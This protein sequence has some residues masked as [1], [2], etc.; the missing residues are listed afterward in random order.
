VSVTGSGSAGD[1]RFLRAGAVV[2]V[3]GTVLATVTPMAA[4]ASAAFTGSI[5]TSGLLGLVFA[6]RNLQLFE[7]T[8]R[9]DAP[10]AVL[11]LVFGLWFM[12]APLLYD[13][14]FLA[15]AGTQLGGLLVSSFAA[16]MSLSGLVGPHG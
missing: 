9:V 16:H 13:V 8:G 5:V 10:A 15:T 7:R 12:L 1:R 3:V 6:G 4:G 2:A 14:G 11:T